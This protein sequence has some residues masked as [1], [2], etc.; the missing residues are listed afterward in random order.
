MQKP[1]SLVRGTQN[2]MKERVAFNLCQ[3]VAAVKVI[4]SRRT[5]TKINELSGLES[6]DNG[7]R[8]DYVGVGFYLQFSHRRVAGP[9]TEADWG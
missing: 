9:Q 3:N 2:E 5:R 4:V 1:M 7:G 6:E 8:F